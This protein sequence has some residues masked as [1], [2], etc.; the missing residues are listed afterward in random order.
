VHGQHARLSDNIHMIQGFNLEVRELVLSSLASGHMVTTAEERQHGVLVL[1]IGAGTTDF[2]LYADGLPLRTG[3]VPVG[4]EH[5]TSDLSLGL[6]LHRDEAEKVKGRYGRAVIQARDKSEIVWLDGTYGI[7]DKKFPRQTVEQITAARVEELFEVV[8]KK[9][10]PGFTPQG[11]RAGVVITG[12]TAKLPG[13]AEA[14]AR[15][16]GV[17]AHLGETP[18]WVTEDLRDPSY[19]TGLGL[20]YYG[21]N[22]QAETAAVTSR[23]K[24]IFAGF[25]RLFAT[26]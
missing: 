16:F 22:A 19:H 25:K 2:V 21:V 23:R 24:S 17:P 15:A 11:V 12:G 4:G 10:G 20:L 14:A 13:I 26:A 7:G 3:V 9:L 6:R 5:L 1:D 18:L 8:K